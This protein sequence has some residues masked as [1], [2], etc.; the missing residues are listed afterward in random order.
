MRDADWA[1]CATAHFARLALRF[2]ERCYDKPLTLSSYPHSD[3]ILPSSPLHSRSAPP[4]L[5]SVHP[6]FPLSRSHR[7][8][9][10]FEAIICCLPRI[11]YIATVFV[12]TRFATT[13]ARRPPP[14][15]FRRVLQPASRI[16]ASKM[17]TSQL[18]YG[19]FKVT[20]THL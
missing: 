5:Q 17:E 13:V 3:S 20:Q 19:N 12:F 9:S 18:R 2:L 8:Q 4:V 10:H 1:Q 6:P 16:F 11:S 7:Q 15:V 14:L